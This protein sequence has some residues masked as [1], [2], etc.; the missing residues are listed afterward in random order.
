MEESISEACGVTYKGQKYYSGGGVVLS[1]NGGLQFGE[2]VTVLIVND[3]PYLICNELETLHF[4][5]HTNSFHTRRITGS[6]V[7]KSIPQLS[8]YHPLGIYQ[9]GDMCIPLRQHISTVL[10]DEYRK[11]VLLS[12]SKSDIKDFITTHFT[13]AM[14]LNVLKS[15]KIYIAANSFI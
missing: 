13:T 15:L 9:L 6:F 3:E 7:V 1:A 14:W 4:E 10:P 2:I 5:G 12:K 11:G 8:D